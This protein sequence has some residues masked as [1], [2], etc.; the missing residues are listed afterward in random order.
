MSGKDTSAKAQNT[1]RVAEPGDGIRQVKTT[2][3]FRLINFELYTRPVSFILNFTKK[4]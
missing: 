4:N 3:V 1:S 2:N